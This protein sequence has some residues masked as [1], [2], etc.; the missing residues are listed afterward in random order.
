LINK[1]DRDILT[2]QYILNDIK[3]STLNYKRLRLFDCLGDTYGQQEEYNSFTNVFDI[4]I[5]ATE[6][7]FNLVFG[8]EENLLN[9]CDF[10]TKIFYQNIGVVLPSRPRAQVDFEIGNFSNFIEC[11]RCIYGEKFLFKERMWQISAKYTYNCN[12]SFHINLCDLDLREN[13]VFSVKASIK[14]VEINAGDY[15][16]SDL[17]EKRLE[18]GDFSAENRSNGFLKYYFSSVS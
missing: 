18:C 15:S 1:F 6:K 8:L 12:L 2:L 11:N 10:Q 3:N 5:L 16:C 9:D 17:F 14:P 4:E 13:E 7:Y